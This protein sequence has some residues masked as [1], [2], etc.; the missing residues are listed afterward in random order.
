MITFFALTPFIILL[1]LMVVLEKPAYISAPITFFITLILS[2]YIWQMDAQWILGSFVRSFSVTIEI[3]LIIFGAIFLLFALRSVGVFKPIEMMFQ[4]VSTD[5]R[6]QAVIIGWFFVSFIEGIAGFGT[7]AMLAA[8][9]LIALGFPIVLS[10]VITLI[11][12]SVAVT[13]GA[14]GVPITIGIAEGVGDTFPV[15]VSA[16]VVGETASLIHMLLS[17]IIPFILILMVGINLGISFRKNLQLWPFA[18][19]SGL[20]F[21]IPSYL[22]AK[23]LTPEFP[24][25]IGALVGGGIMIFL[26]R[27]GL[28]Q[29]KECYSYKKETLEET[30]SSNENGFSTKQIFKSL[31]P[32]ILIIVLLLLTRLETF[33]FS[34][35]LKSISFS[36]PNILN[37]PTSHELSILYSPGTIFIAVVFL[38]LFVGYINFTQFRNSF[39]KS[40]Y[41][42]GLPFI[43]LLFVLAIVQ[44]MIFSGNNLSGYESMPM[45]LAGSLTDLGSAWPFLAPFVGVLGSF[46][47]GSS[48]VSNLL[49]STLQ[50]TTAIATGLNV[51]LILALQAVGSSIGNMVAIHNIIAAQ[52]AVGLSGKEGAIL[53]KTLPTVLLYSTLAGIIGLVL[54][55]FIF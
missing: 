15:A 20:L 26:L 17:P 14:V 18:L 55:F 53:R 44:I 32:Y 30:L 9:I 50:G 39:Q 5:S 52:S 37:L 42:I 16:L 54:S 34:E 1:V 36:I 31:L 51:V 4:K 40:V 48:T 23:F 47:S 25:I 33:G 6:I 12:D 41:K 45:E 27:R 3:M 22:V 28:F 7:P 35:K 29:P 11:G 13:F 49:F 8:P 21:T 19:V 46:I 43:G 2:I 24:S 10:V 38:G